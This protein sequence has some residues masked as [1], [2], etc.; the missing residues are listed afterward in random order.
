MSTAFQAEPIPLHQDEQGDIRVGASHV[1]LD[2]VI[3]AF[4]DGATPE[5][6]MQ[7]YP[8][9]KLADVYGAITYYLRHKGEVDSYLR[10]REQRAVA[11]RKNVD[12]NQNNMVEIRRQLLDRQEQAGSSDAAVA[13]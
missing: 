12:L 11:V 9:L 3:H 2:L 10:H 1:L 5:A 7:M 8:T 6:I 13:E 4:Q